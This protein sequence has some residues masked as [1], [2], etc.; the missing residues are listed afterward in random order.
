M[1]RDAAF[2]MLFNDWENGSDA[3]P[4]YGDNPTEDPQSVVPTGPLT[5]AAFPA[6][7]PEIP[8]IF[9]PAAGGNEYVVTGTGAITITSGDLPTPWLHADR[10]TLGNIRGDGVGSKNITFELGAFDVL[11]EGFIAGVASTMSSST[12]GRSSWPMHPAPAVSAARSRAGRSPR[13]PTT[14]MLPP[15]G[16]PVISN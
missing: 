6:Y 10:F 12:P 14:G 7:V 2:R 3:F 4:D 9:V 8:Q 5:Y 15:P 16:V 13:A 11:V 1:L